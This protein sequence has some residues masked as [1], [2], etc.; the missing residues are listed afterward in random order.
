MGWTQQ[1]VNILTKFLLKVLQVDS[2]YCRF[3][4]EGGAFTRDTLYTHFCPKILEIS[5]KTAE[6]TRISPDFDP[7]GIYTHRYIYP[8]SPVPPLLLTRF[9]P[10]DR[11]KF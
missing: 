11:R 6:N 2:G 3:G 7:N 8:S 4:G 5:P 1:P 10:V 9:R